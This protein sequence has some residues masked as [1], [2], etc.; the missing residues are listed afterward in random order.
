MISVAFCS[1]STS[2]V[3]CSPKYT[4][5]MS[6]R[7]TTKS[8]PLAAISGRRGQDA[9]RS[10]NIRAGRTLVYSPMAPRSFNKPRSGRLSAGWSSHL[11]PPTAPSSTLSDFM[12]VSRLESGRGT[13]KVSMAL[14]PMGAS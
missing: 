12:Q 1:P 7:T 10:E 4:P 8:M 2:A 13:P 9:D 14:P 6:S 5:P 3:E 11:G